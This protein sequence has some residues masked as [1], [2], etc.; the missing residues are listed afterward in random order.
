MDS[1]WTEYRRLLNLLVNAYESHFDTLNKLKGIRVSRQDFQEKSTAWQRFPEPGPYSVDFVDDLWNKVQAKDREIETA[2]L[3]QAMFVGLLEAQ[4]LA[5]T[6]SEQALRKAAE[7]L[8]TAAKDSVDRACWLKDL[9]EL[10]N[11]HDQA[12]MAA[13]DAE[14]EYREEMLSYRLDERALLQ[15]EAFAAIVFLRFPKKMLM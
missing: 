8:E 12:R 3:E 4:R 11:L 15:R 13:L 14:R 10:R 6:H 2:R 1:E 7:T 9:S 5:L